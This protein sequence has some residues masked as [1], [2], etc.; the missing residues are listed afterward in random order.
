MKVDDRRT[1]MQNSKMWPMLHDIA[2]QVKW[3]VNGVMVEMTP[4]DW[5]H[6]LSAGFKKEQRVAAGIDGGYVILGQ[7]TS[8]FTKEEMASFIE[9]M[10]AFGADREPPVI[11][12]EES[13]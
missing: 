2:S 13:R 8:K 11:W 4:D 6:V 12:S 10:Y 1:T 7:H 5:K 9:L 3:P